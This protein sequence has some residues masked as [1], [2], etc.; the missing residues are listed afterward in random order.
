MI[1]LRAALLLLLL[2]G[3]QAYH[4]CQSSNHNCKT[5]PFAICQSCSK[6]NTTAK[7]A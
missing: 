7:Q 5:Q 3:Q 1:L 4:G 6:H 2:L